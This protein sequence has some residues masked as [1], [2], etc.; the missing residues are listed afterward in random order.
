MGND[1]RLIKVAPQTS[2]H[3]ILIADRD[4]M[5]AE[6]LAHALEQSNSYHASAVLTADLLNM[7]SDDDDVSLIII[8]AN[9]ENQP[10]RGI[11]L[12]R[13]IN[14]AFP[15][16]PVLI[17]QDSPTYEVTIHGFRAG[18]RGVFSRQD[19]MSVFL[20]C[21]EHVRK[22]LLWSGVKETDYLLRAL[23]QMPVPRLLIDKDSSS[24][25]AREW[26]VVRSAAKGKTN[27]IIA[28]ELGLSEHTVKNYLFRAFEKIGVSNRVELLFHLTTHEQF[29][30]SESPEEDNDLDG[31]IVSGGY[32]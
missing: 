21:V 3:R 26:Q 2:V 31:E 4:S 14:Q 18:A 10:G 13:Q 28:S 6:L 27:K 5:T 24:L 8:G 25:T 16:I 32:I 15:E 20:E 22:G 29:P 30:I 23:R 19:P 11:E 7:L 1:K 9:I 17:I 12:T